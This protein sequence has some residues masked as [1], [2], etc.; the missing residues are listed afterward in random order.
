VRHEVHVN[1]ILEKAGFLKLAPGSK[2]AE[3]ALAAISE[4]SRAFALDP[5]R[6]YLHRKGRFPKGQVGEPEVSSLIGELTALFESVEHE[7]EKIVRRV[8]KGKDVYRGPFVSQGPDLL[9]VPRNGY[10]MKGRLG[11]PSMIA[12]RRLQG[13]H[14]WDD[15]FFFSGRSDL[16]SSTEELTI[17]DVP[18]KVLRSLDVQT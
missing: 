9:L 6:I 5:A 17:V 4:T 12:E 10:D 1:T 7:G 15:A 8:F 2:G 11:R 14:T 3:S 16:L 18:W 13:M